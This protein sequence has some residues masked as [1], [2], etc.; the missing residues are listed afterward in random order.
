MHVPLTDLALQYQ[1][2][3]S[4]ID[5]GIRRVF[6]AADFTNSTWVKRFEEAFAGMHGARHCIAV[7]NGTAALHAVL[8]A[9]GIGP[10]DEVI[11]P[12]TTFVATA[13][14]VSLTGAR[15]VFTDI[16]PDTCTLDPPK[17]KKLI[18]GNT[19]A[20]IPVHLY[21]QM[22]SVELLADMLKSRGIPLIEDCAQAHLAR[23]KGRYA[24]TM[25]LAGCFSFYPV[26]NLGAFGEGGAILTDDDT[27]ADELRSIRT[28][29]SAGKF[30]IER[31]GHNYRLS[32]IQGSIL[33]KKLP[34]L[35]RWTDRRREIADLYRNGLG[36]ID[37]LRLPVIADENEHVF[38]L[39]VIQTPMRDELM[40]FLTAHK[41]QTGLHYP[42][43]C[44]LQPVY[45]KPGYTAGDLP[46][47]ERHAKECLSLPMSESHS[48]H[49]IQY[50][51]RQIRQF[52]IDS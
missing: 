1:S 9:L 36:D 39:Y 42:V 4:E 35:T 37:G 48:N 3:K 45:K 51:I 49:Q 22:A 29:G 18:N 14:A 52:F 15:P 7:S 16:T 27:L 44:H 41:I 40:N 23:R 30:L 50:V 2:I 17:V 19:K 8:M 32:E 43:P 13:M 28:Y 33:E 21:G 10:G 26:K 47:S 34:H 25:G 24:G 46:V 11:V 31:I 6:E 20:V 12:A 38:H 5:E